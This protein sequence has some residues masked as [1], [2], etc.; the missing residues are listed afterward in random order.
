MK[1][2]LLFIATSVAFA[3]TAM[4]ASLNIGVEAG[5]DFAD[6]M[7]S[8]SVQTNLAINNSSTGLLS[9]YTEQ[10]R[11]GKIAGTYD[12]ILVG[13]VPKSGYIQE[14]R[15]NVGRIPSL[16][17]FHVGPTFNWTFSDKMGLGLR[18]GINYHYLRTNGHVFDS[19]GSRSLVNNKNIFSGYNT[20]S[21]SLNIPIRLSYTWELPQDWNIWVMVGP[22]F[23]INLSCTESFDVNIDGNW[24]SYRMDYLSGKCYADGNLIPW[25]EPA[26]VSADRRERYHKFNPFS[27]YWGLG[28]GFG[29]KDFSFSVLYDFGCTNRYYLGSETYQKATA[30][31]PV[32]GEML[33]DLAVETTKYKQKMLD[34]ELVVSIAY[35]FPII[36]KSVKMT[37]K[38][39][40]ELTKH[41]IAANAEKEAEVKAIINKY[42]K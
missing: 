33:E 28:F 12:A 15:T 31:D 41:R 1:K 19:T 11:I 2:T 13:G 26:G 35:T 40:G 30:F 21:H 37:G 18:F 38:R 23:D 27:L 29:Y 25:E 42:C 9:Y 10:Y 34:N 6:V 36:K 14:S 4:A 20:T 32:T 22:K 24:H 5:Y 7:T 39:K 3:T 16:H 8:S 17:G